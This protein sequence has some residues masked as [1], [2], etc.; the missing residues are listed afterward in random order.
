[1][2]S[3]VVMS[4]TSIRST[5]LLP[6]T[7]D[8]CTLCGK[9]NIHQANILK[10]QILGESEKEFIVKHYGKELP[11]D[12]TMCKA[13]YVEAERKASDTPKWAKQGT[14]Q[15]LD[16]N[17]IT[18]VYSQCSDSHKLITPSFEALENLKTALP[19]KVNP[20]QPMVLCPSYYHK[21]HR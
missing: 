14:A 16:E 1:M 15:A 2:L 5:K 11:S 13:H 10:C 20:D 18:C 17:Q 8:S 19:L 21:L 3:T 6:A 7:E 9:T 4:S 12:S